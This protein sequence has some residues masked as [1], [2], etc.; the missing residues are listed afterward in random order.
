MSGRSATL[1]TW[2]A[3]LVGAVSVDMVPAAGPALP[4][5]QLPASV[6]DLTHTFCLDCHHRGDPT[7]GIDLEAIDLQLSVGSV[8]TVRIQAG[9]PR[10]LTYVSM[11]GAISVASWW[12]ECK[13]R[14]PKLVKDQ[15]YALQHCCQAC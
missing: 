10:I 14:G 13:Q 9:T 11:P 7:A 1:A 2:L 15:F 6:A 3:I 8:P 5:S 12:S 4:D